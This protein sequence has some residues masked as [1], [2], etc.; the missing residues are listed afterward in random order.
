MR[1]SQTLLFTAITLAI[2]TACGGGGNDDN[3]T[4]MASGNQS[5][6]ALSGTV[7]DGYIEG[8]TVCLDSNS[9]GACD[10]DETSV[11]T[12]KDGQFKLEVGATS[13]AGLNLVVDI[14]KTAKDSDDNGLTLE[15]AGKSGYTMATTADQPSVITPLTTLLV[16]KIKT[17]G[18]TMAA[19]KAQVL[20]DLGLP[21]NT[22]F[23]EDH[24]K[25]PNPLVHSMARETAARLQKAQAAYEALPAKDRPK[26]RLKD[27]ADK[28][29]AAD[30]QLGTLVKNTPLTKLPTKVA[31]LATG[32]LVIYKMRNVK[33]ELI[34]ASALLF[35]PKE[36]APT[37]GRPLVVFGHGTTGIDSL[38]A[39]SNILQATGVLG[40]EPFI[41]AMLEKNLA[42]IMPDY[43]GRGPATED[44][45]NAHP[46]LHLGSAGQS[47]AL[48]AV[49]AK[50]VTDANLS[51]AWAAFGHS[52]G[53]HAALAAAQFSELA[54]KQSTT[55]SYKG[56]VAVAPASNFL[57]ALNLMTDSIAKAPAALASFDLLGTSNFYASYLIQG[58][59]FTTKPID[60]KIVLGARLQEVHKKANTCLGAYFATLEADIT[61]FAD[62]KKPATAY[63]GVIV[64]EINK[65]SVASVLKAMEPGTFKL[66]GKTLIVQ[67]ASD[68]TVLP[69]ASDILQKL[70]KAKGSETNYQLF[71]DVTGQ[72][73]THSGVL[74]IPAAQ[75][76]IF[77][78]IS[79]LFTPPAP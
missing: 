54:K 57:P 24:I 21:E 73:A 58:S 36:S 50:A 18:L 34:N 38:C 6:N 14:P 59:S 77:N 29:K 37:G 44:V 46:Y 79:A 5:G 49:A 67:G 55:L 70:M 76:A 25:A 48:S 72:P 71:A 39:P 43:E 4:G 33:G 23:H 69:T 31:N 3:Q 66:P 17:D 65:P 11:T 68:T 75:Q 45:P 47:F 32:Q 7:I 78:H 52:Q 40:Y 30:A 42:V 28:F 8:A 19:A 61:A 27:F 63:T 51:G 74:A 22:N 12:G 56:T 26:D 35:T 9:N 1:S 64:S 13:T 41:T 20:K 16:S 62:E 10:A 60:P 2:L 15:Q 53:G